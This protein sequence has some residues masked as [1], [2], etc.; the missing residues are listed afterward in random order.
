L[1]ASAGTEDGDP[2]EL[3][4]RQDLLTLLDQAMRLLSP[5]TREA[6]TLCYLNDLPQREVAARLG[7]TNNA[8]EVRLH[9]A[10]RQ[11][12]QILSNELRA[13]AEDFGL[14]VD[15]ETDTGWRETRLWCNSCG[16]HHLQGRFEQES[17][18]RITMQLRCPECWARHKTYAVRSTGTYFGQQPRAFLPAHKKFL[19]RNAAFHI[20]AIANGNYAPCPDCGQ[21]TVQ[22]QVVLGQDVAAATY[23]GL[24]YFLYRCPDCGTGFSTISTLGAAHPVARRFLADHPRSVLEPETLV[25]H[26]GHPA[27]RFHMRDV[28]SAAQLTAFADNATLAVYDVF[29]E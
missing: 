15:A 21:H 27:Y 9:R 14:L 20:G 18:G 16:Q 3:F 26:A 10:R 4:S 24:H 13:E 22:L 7:L 5:A 2:A 11:F 28:N 17:D 12:R 29:V 1:L 23:P 8:L 25:E 6:L 19:Q